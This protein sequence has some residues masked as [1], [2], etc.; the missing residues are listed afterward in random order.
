MMQLT[1]RTP[2]PPPG[3][4]ADTFKTIADDFAARLASGIAAGGADD[5]AGAVAV[6]SVRDLA[7]PLQFTEE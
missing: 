2:G 4:L 3:D 5:G 7:S 6:V 1:R